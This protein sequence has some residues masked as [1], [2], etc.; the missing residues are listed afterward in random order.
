MPELKKTKEEVVKFNEGQKVFVPKTTF[1]F[2]TELIEVY[3]VFQDDGSEAL[4]L[5]NKEG[6]I[7]MRGR[8]MVFGDIVIAKQ[9]YLNWLQVMHDK[10]V[11]SWKPAEQSAEQKAP[12]AKL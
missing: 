9:Y 5:V 7:I 11:E 8:G 12:E 6:H 10:L 4:L 3:N 1:A 2:D